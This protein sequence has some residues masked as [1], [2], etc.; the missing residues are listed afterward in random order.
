[1]NLSR[2]LRIKMIEMPTRCIVAVFGLAICL[3]ACS[4]SDGAAPRLPDAEIAAP[5]PKTTPSR[6]I[7]DARTEHR[8][9]FDVNDHSK[10][11]VMKL[12]ERAQ[13]IYDSL[14]NE[15]RDSLKIAMVL[16][17][18]DLQYFAKNNYLQNKALVDM[19]AKLEAFGFIDLKVCAVSARSHGVE[20]DGFPPFIEVVPYGPN[21]INELQQRGYTKL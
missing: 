18:P 2:W 14:P 10:D 6:S 17:G 19:A 21:E 13:E 20:N 1:M 9:Y 8:Y 15:Q 4:G 5:V 7:A 12:L 3:V 16:H 11:E